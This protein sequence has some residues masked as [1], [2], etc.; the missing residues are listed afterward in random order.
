MGYVPISRRLAQRAVAAQTRFAGFFA[1]CD[2][3]WR[4]TGFLPVLASNIRWSA[5]LLKVAC[6]FRRAKTKTLWMWMTSKCA[7]VSIPYGG[8]KSGMAV[9]PKRLSMGELERLTRRF[10]REIAPIIGPERDIPAPNVGTNVQIMA[11]MTNVYLQIEGYSVLGVVTGKPLS[12]GCPTTGTRRSGTCRCPRNAFHAIFIACFST[13]SVFVC[14][15]TN[16]VISRAKNRA[17][18]CMVARGAGKNRWA[19]TSCCLARFISAGASGVAR[20]QSGHARVRGSHGARRAASLM[21][22]LISQIMESQRGETDLFF[23]PGYAPK[24]N[25]LGKGLKLADDGYTC[26]S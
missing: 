20:P 26:F 3:Q 13:S 8:A 6:V 23:A 18:S 24:K 19:F 14:D 12:I 1:G 10:T 7:V 17:R 21:K 11:W 4:R 9:D 2:G 15:S 5:A 16:G 25:I 22:R